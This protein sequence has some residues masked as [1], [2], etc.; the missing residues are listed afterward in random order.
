MFIEKADYG[1]GIREPKHQQEEQTLHMQIPWMRQRVWQI[2]GTE[3]N[4]IKFIA[5]KNHSIA[6][7]VVLVSLKRAAY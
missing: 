4:T 7:H 2:S 3:L 1:Q 6:K 5:E